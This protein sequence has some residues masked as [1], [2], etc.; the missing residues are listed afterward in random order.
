M[1]KYSRSIKTAFLEQAVDG[2]QNVSMFL[3]QVVSHIGNLKHSNKTGE[4][5]EDG[6]DTK[7][8]SINYGPNGGGTFAHSGIIG[9]LKCKKGA[10]RIVIYIQHTDSLKF[11]FIPY[12]EWTKMTCMNGKY[13]RLSYST[14]KDQV[15]RLSKYEVAFVEMCKLR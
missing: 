1:S 2:T 5:H 12:P 3:E 9:N 10:L 14:K 11:Y 7:F 15:S 6:S 4:D 8:A 13:L